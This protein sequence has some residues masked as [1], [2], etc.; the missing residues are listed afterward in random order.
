MTADLAKQKIPVT[1]NPRY[2]SWNTSTFGF[3]GMGS[4][5]LPSVVTLGSTLPGDQK[6]A[7]SQ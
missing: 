6:S 5:Q 3:T 4:K 1:V 7:P 2:G